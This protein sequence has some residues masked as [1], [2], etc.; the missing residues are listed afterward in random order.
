[1]KRLIKIF[2]AISAV[3]GVLAA[4]LLVIALILN[5]VEI[6]IRST[7]DRT[8]FITDEYSGYLMC[9]VTFLA[10]AYTLREKSHIRMTFLHSLV[11]DRPRLYL[12]TFCYTIGTLFS[13]FVTHH[14][15]SHFWDSL[16]TGS[17]SVQ[18]SA[19]YLAIPQVFMPVGALIL[20]LQLLSE[21]FKSL[22]LLRGEGDG[23]EIKT[24][25]AE[26]GR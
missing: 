5:T 23:L 11:K 10:L 24:E 20:T 13:G 12:D 3:A 21:L 9:G 18:L 25:S 1:M 26:L 4:V 17:Q 22:L 7:I 15:F 6:L 2:D 19:T 8:L 16:A 14:T